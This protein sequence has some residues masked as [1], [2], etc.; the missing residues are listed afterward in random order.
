MKMI[1]HRFHIKL[2]NFMIVNIKT[3]YITLKQNL[4]IDVQRCLSS[5]YSIRPN[6]AYFVSEFPG[7][8]SIN[9]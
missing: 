4:L 8:G 5:F 6:V 7:F 3:N 1:L 2:V 9:N